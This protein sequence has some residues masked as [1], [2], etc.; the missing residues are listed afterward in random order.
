LTQMLNILQVVGVCDN[1]ISTVYTLLAT[2]D[3]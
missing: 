2:S 1:P 3:C